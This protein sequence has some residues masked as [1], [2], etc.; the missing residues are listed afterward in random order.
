MDSMKLGRSRSAFT[1]IELLVVVG[2]IGV[3]AAILFPVFASIRERGR[4]TQ[5]L[6]NERQLGMAMMQYVADHDETF[7][8]GSICTGDRWVSQ[9]YPYVRDIVLFH[10]PG[11][12]SI[13]PAGASSTGGFPISYGLNQNLGASVRSDSGGRPGIMVRGSRLPELLAPSRSV[14]FFEVENGEAVVNNCPHTQDGST[15]G[16]AGLDGSATGDASGNLTTDPTFPNGS[17]VG[18]PR[19]ATGNI[20]G[21]LLNGATKNGKPL[22]GA[23]GSVARHGEGAD[24]LA[25][26]GHAVWLRPEMVS[27]GGDAV[28][29]DCLQG[30]ES[31]QASGCRVLNNAAGTAD[32]RYGLTFSRE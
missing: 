26:D 6:S 24:Y 2:I 23:K 31:G 8:S 18:L 1:L 16:R 14:L 9:T 11:D 27:G 19:Y 22:E 10:C 12:V 15:W 4:R 7:P 13:D 3:I 30:T 21:R 29:A 32:S 28:A 25:C 17:T 5:C 20:G